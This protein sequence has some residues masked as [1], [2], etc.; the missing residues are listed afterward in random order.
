MEPIDYRELLKK[1]MQ[2][3]G[4]CESTYYTGGSLIISDRFTEEEKE[5]LRKLSNSLDN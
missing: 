2:H 3:I 1:Y 5:E 4:D